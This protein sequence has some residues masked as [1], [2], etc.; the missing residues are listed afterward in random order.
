MIIIVVLCV[1]ICVELIHT[2]L[3]DYAVSLLTDY[4]VSSPT[5]LN[6]TA[7]KGDS[8]KAMTYRKVGRKEV[9]NRPAGVVL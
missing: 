5:Q 4:A 6:L 7:R 3:T 2:L 1:Y 9:R 8:I